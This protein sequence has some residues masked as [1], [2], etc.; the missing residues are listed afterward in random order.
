VEG[1]SLAARVVAILICGLPLCVMSL[2]K[3]PATPAS[4]PATKPSGFFVDTLTACVE[5][6]GLEEPEMTTAQQTKRRADIWRWE[7]A[8]RGA[9]IKVEAEV[10]DVE[11]RWL[12]DSDFVVVT[13]SSQAETVTGAVEARFQKK[14]LPNFASLKR[15]QRVAITGVVHRLSVLPTVADPVSGTVDVVLIGERIDLSP[16]PKPPPPQRPPGGN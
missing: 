15:G 14:K 6:F 12:N 7:F 8:N 10:V 3:R 11:E 1:I 9:R 16:A 5:K 4:R 2:D 13:A